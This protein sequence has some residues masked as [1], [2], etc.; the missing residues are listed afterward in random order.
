MDESDL[1]VDQVKVED[2]KFGLGEDFEEEESDDSD[3]AS[4]SF[5]SNSYDN[6]S[7]VEKKPKKNL[8]ELFQFKQDVVSMW[9]IKTRSG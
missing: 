6:E 2:V 3:E 9:Q 5:E 7:E 4:D 8:N 1:I